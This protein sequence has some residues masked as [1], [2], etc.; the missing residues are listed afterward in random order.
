ME[1]MKRQDAADKPDRRNDRRDEGLAGMHA[2][3]EKLFSFAEF[4]L[5]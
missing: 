4:C 3:N 1:A 5:L 2:I